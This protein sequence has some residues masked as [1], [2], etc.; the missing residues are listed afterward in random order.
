M[1]GS[2]AEGLA[3]VVVGEVT[4]SNRQRQGDG[5]RYLQQ[6]QHQRQQS[7]GPLAGFTESVGEACNRALAMA[8]TASSYFAHVYH[9]K[10]LNSLAYITASLLIRS[11]ISRQIISSVTFLTTIFS[12][13]LL[14]SRQVS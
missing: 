8:I 3:G 7:P 11:H 4:Q 13:L 5:P 9:G 12:I 10:F 1:I 2:L 6:Q 14:I